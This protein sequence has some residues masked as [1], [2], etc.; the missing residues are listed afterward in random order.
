MAQ[1]KTTISVRSVP[2]LAFLAIFGVLPLVSLVASQ[3]APIALILLA[4]FVLTAFLLHHFTHEVPKRSLVPDKA[5]IYWL[6]VM[7]FCLAYIAASASWSINADD[8]LQR[9]KRLSLLLAVAF[10][11]LYAVSRMPCP[12]AWMH[13]SV[14]IGVTLLLILTLLEAAF[15]ILSDSFWASADAVEKAQILNR[16]ATYLVLLVWPA[17]LAARRLSKPWLSWG[18]IG[19][20]PVVLAASSATAAAMA[21]LI[22]ALAFLATL[23]S[24]RLAASAFALVVFVSVLGMPFA[25]TNGPL[26]TSLSAAVKSSGV[27]SFAHRLGIWNFVAASSFENPILG[28]GANTARHLPGATQPLSEAKSFA[29]YLEALDPTFPTLRES[30]AL[31]L[32][33]HNVALQLHLEL[34]VVGALLFCGVATAVIFFFAVENRKNTAPFTVAWAASWFVI[35]YLSIGFWQTWWWALSAICLIQFAYFRHTVDASTCAESNDG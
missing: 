19:C 4:I 29:P 22:G 14:V 2:V 35:A 21:G 34:G 9:L 11:A 15:G 17:A 23:L 18:L 13:W 27:F 16:P 20:V 12:Q 1:H 32:H 7:G 25:V 6:I 24:R 31:P 8:S 3:Q 5:A 10:V 30:P 28:T 33:P 26:M